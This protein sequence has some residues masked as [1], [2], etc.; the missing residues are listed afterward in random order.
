MAKAIHL[1]LPRHQI[2]GTSGTLQAVSDMTATKEMISRIKF[3]F[4]S[5]ENQ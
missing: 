1:Q 3:P 4:Q 2:N 5:Y